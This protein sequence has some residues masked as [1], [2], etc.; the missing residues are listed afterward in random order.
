MKSEPD[1]ITKNDEKRFDEFVADR[2]REK[3]IIIKRLCPHC[4]SELA[5]PFPVD[6]ENDPVPIFI[7][8]DN[9]KTK[10]IWTCTTCGGVSVEYDD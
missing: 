6:L 8:G 7:M 3:P 10:I 1:E 9:K 2:E 5:I 4:F